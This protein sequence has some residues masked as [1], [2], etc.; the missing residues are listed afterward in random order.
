MK[1]ILNYLGVLLVGI[2]IG[3]VCSIVVRSK[4]TEP[5]RTVIT[6]DT[7]RIKEPQPTIVTPVAVTRF[8]TVPTLL[9]ISDTVKV[10]YY[11]HDTL[12]IP[13]EQRYYQSEEYQ[14]WISGFEPKLDSINIFQKTTTTT[15]T[16]TRRPEHLL[17]LEARFMAA[18]SMFLPGLSM[19][20]T[21]RGLFA[22]VGGIYYNG[23]K[24]YVQV[25]YSFTIFSK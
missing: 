16:I 22:E 8:T 6:H 10:P 14:A 19:R 11:V 12:M 7:V 1:T 15:N 2:I 21:S 3:I 23:V 17:T 24:P 5:I 25:G 13:I 18:P 20:Y 9:T 4:L